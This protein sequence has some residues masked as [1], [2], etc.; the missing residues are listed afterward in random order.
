MTRSFY[1]IPAIFC[2]AAAVVTAQ[3]PAQDRPAA[4]APAAEQPAAQQPTTPKPTTP[5]STQP[6]RPAEPSSQT[7]R[8]SDPSSTASANTVTY[9]GCIKPGT[10][11]GTWV[12]EN[13]EAAARPG[14]SSPGT[15][16][17]SGTAKTMAF[18]LEPAATASG[19]NLKAHANHKVELVGTV[20]P[21]KGMAE[22]PSASAPPSSTPGAA[23]AQAARQQ[24]S[25][26]S[27][28]MVSATCP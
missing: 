4:N 1:A 27:L 19:V 16:G 8:P 21:A 12:L 9:T 7:A 2:L 11:S 17:T 20:S 6:A 24:F 5:P 25:V 26:Q 10:T 23:T 13:A 14:A 22:T 28:K 18:D 3:A 15:V